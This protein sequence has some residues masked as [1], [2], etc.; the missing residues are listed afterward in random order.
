MV[1][2]ENRSPGRS[3]KVPLTLLTEQVKLP[4]H[5][6]GERAVNR[7]CFII[8]ILARRIRQYHKPNGLSG[9]VPSPDALK[10]CEN[11]RGDLPS[12]EYESPPIRNIH[13]SLYT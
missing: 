12:L 8:I 5:Q 13:Q 11:P 2:T 1:G 6:P 10:F 4:P 3:R 9:A 7:C